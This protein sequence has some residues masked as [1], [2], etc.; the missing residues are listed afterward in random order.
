MTRIRR[1]LVA[2][3]GEIA[4]RVFRSCREM[5]IGTV[6]VFSEP[7]REAPFV[8]EAQEAVALGGE[9]AAESYLRGDAV[10]D[11]AA[12]AGAD[13]VHPGYGFLAESAAFAASCRE[14]GL[15][16]VGPPA[17]AIAAMGLKL[18]ARAIAERAGVPVLPA[19]EVGEDPLRAADAVGWPLI[20]KASAGG[21]GRGMRLVRDAAAL[22][23]A[24]ASAR[25]EAA[26]AFGDATLYLERW[27]EPARHVEIQVLAD[28]H[29]AVA[30]LFERE[31]SIQ[32]RHQKIVEE[33]PSPAL[34]ETPGLGA[35]MSEAALALT[36]AVGYLGAGTVEFLLAPDGRFYF[37]EMNTRLQ[38][39]HPVT[40]AV[41]GLDLVRL[42][43]Q[44]AQGEPLPA[45]V[46]EAR[47]QGHAIEARLYAED[48]RHGFLPRT[49][50]LLRFDLGADPHLRV[51]AG[52]ETGSVV[53]PHYDPLLAKVIAHAGTRPE[54]AAR[55][56]AGLAAARI[57][58]LDTNRDLLV[59]VLRHPD[60]LAGHTDT[61]FLERHAASLLAPLVDAGG[62]ERH[63]IAAALAGAAG[64]RKA[65]RVL[66]FAPPAWRNNPSQPQRSVFAG[67]HGLAVVEYSWRRHEVDASV[68]GRAL[69]VRLGRLSEEVV[70][71]EADGV[72]RSYDVHQS[73]GRV[74]VDGPE[75]SSN[76]SEED[77]FP[78]PAAAADA[79]SLRSPM[80]GTV[81]RV[82][83][84]A[85]QRVAAGAVVA[86]IEAMKM[87]HP[88]ASP[89]EGRV[90]EM[91]VSAGQAVQAGY[92]LAVIDPAPTP[93]A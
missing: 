11:A 85:G 29:G 52:V 55:L 5:G 69:T 23:E 35:A 71:I 73:A 3:R 8:R 44:A 82:E 2:N 9:T 59:R 43:I 16:F 75:G 74:F 25:R 88:V 57:H 91:R 26:A 47:A 22:P 87:E 76:L 66:G 62:E 83:V 68:N 40:E 12:R 41:T 89:H 70:D 14:R 63:A 86:V 48:P 64:R 6:A 15:V 27:M 60:F 79:G 81:I 10:L 39:E 56:S 18:R 92:V 4:R 72:R 42:Q 31:C 20:V 51:E 17:E 34:A 7:D 28:A 38:V 46:R 45:S 13:A 77:R 80:P 93:T 33:A 53:S 32:R 49:G 61:G 84:E 54:A 36:R 21:G 37:L 90:A 67:R 50:R 1:L 24:V 30:H 65:A 58:G 19:C 78:A